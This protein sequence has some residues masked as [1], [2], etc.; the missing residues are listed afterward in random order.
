MIYGAKRSGTFSTG[1]NVREVEDVFAFY[2][3]APPLGV[4]TE[5]EHIDQRKA[6]VQKRWAD[7]LPVEQRR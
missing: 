2:T 5:F 7:H 6:Q 4:M 3:I 1:G